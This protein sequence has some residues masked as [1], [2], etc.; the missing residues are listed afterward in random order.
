MA[1]DVV[2]LVDGFGGVRSLCESVAAAFGL[3]ILAYDDEDDGGGGAPLSDGVSVGV[4]AVG[5]IFS[6]ATAFGAV[7]LLA[8][9]MIAQLWGFAS[10]C[11]CVDV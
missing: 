10:V 8:D 7:A 4:V 5:A 6:D 11:V 2:V 9:D 1:G 3:S